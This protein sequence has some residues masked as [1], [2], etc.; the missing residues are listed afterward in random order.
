MKR[1]YSMMFLV[2]AGAAAAGGA[3]AQSSGKTGMFD[4]WG[5]YVHTAAGKKTCYILTAPIP[6]SA[7]PKTLDHGDNYFLV[8]HK[9]GENVSFEPQFIAGYNMQE[10]GKVTVSV[11]DRSFSMFTRGKSAW[12]ENA[13]EEPA[14]IAAMRNGS[15]MKIAAKSGRGNPTS[16]EF[17]LKGVTKALQQIQTCK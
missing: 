6:N 2:L 7:T 13:A 3:M 15:T 14:L 9:P 12:M 10:N 1:V 4:A 5:T 16:Y 8:S 17:S 11:G